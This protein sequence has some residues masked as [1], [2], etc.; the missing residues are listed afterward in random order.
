MPRT[1]KKTTSK[2]TKPEP[3]ATQRSTFY[4]YSM[5]SSGWS[6]GKT[7]VEKHVEVFDKDGKVSG[8]YQEKK[9]GKVVK[10][11]KITNKK[12]ITNL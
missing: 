8:L 9:D 6:N 5:S 7:T 1:D 4:S 11:K 2:K 12:Q 10:Q 3:D